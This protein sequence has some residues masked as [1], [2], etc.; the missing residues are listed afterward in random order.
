MYVL[1]AIARAALATARVALLLGVIVATLALA[2]FAGR[3][4]GE[5]AG[6][7]QPQ[8]APSN[9]TVP[10]S[11]PVLGYSIELPATYRRVASS[12]MN[13]PELLGRDTYTFLTEADE[14]AE[15]LR[16]GSDLPS[17]SLATYIEMEVHR[18]P[19]G[20]AVHDWVAV[21][22]YKSAR[23]TLQS[24]SLP[25]GPAVRLVENGVTS[26]YAIQANERIYVL[27]PRMRPSPHPLDAIATSLRA[28]PPQPFSAPAARP[29]TPARDAVSQVAGRLA[30]AFARRD[31][32]AVAREMGSC[33]LGVWASIDSTLQGGAL[34]RSAPLFVHALR[35]RLA[36]GDVTV[37]VDPTVQVL[38]EVGGRERY[39]V[40]SSWVGPARTNQV[41]LFI[42]EADGRW[43]WTGAQH[44]FQR[45]DLVNQSCVPF[46]SPWVVGS[47]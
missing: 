22:P 29:A 11:S 3:A 41:R 4:L 17:P 36:A 26:G 15:C 19:A 35:G 45:A 25:A 8:T 21:S 16:D 12:L 39:F 44:D 38:T 43:L 7:P 13:L 5:R 31:A 37:N 46:G 47:C 1:L 27:F 10:H 6:S 42:E 18:A 2:T 33:R 30:T 9:V 34:L 23:T 24:A 28:T 20:V 40:S 32:D 14:R